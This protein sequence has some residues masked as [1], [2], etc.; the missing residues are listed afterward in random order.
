MMEKEEGSELE[1]EL[2]PTTK[3][4]RDRD[5]D[6]DIVPRGRPQCLVKMLRE[7]TR[8]WEI[9]GHKREWESVGGQWGVVCGGGESGEMPWPRLEMDWGSGREPLGNLEM[10]ACPPHLGH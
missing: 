5:Q 7:G 8:T 9:G 1:Y 4:N 3:I 2:A 6:R 10:E